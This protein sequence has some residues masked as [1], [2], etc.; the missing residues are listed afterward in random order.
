MEI[1]ELD[2]YGVALVGSH[3]S[4][5]VL[6]DIL[7][8]LPVDFPAALFVALHMLP[9]KPSLLADLLSKHTKLKIAAP[10]QGEYIRSG[11]VYIT[12]PDYHMLVTAYGTINYVYARKVNFARPSADVLLESIAKYFKKKAIAVI[13]SGFGNDGAQGARIIKSMGGS[14]IAQSKETC[15]ATGMPNAAIK[16]G[17]VDL[18]SPANKIAEN[19]SKYVTGSNNY[20]ILNSDLPSWAKL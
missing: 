8:R 9:N 2:Y 5:P 16:T 3:G 10:R 1:V 7:N 18:I 14:I 11:A 19:I 12:I 20:K 15:L 17:C 4:I 13:L 6:R